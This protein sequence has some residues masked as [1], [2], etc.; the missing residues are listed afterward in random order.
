MA[1]VF[2]IIQT[3][4]NREF[5]LFGA[6][7][8]TNDNHVAL[9]YAGPRTVCGI[10]LDGDD[11]IASGDTFEGEITCISCYRIIV[12]IKSIRNWQRRT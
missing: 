11:G 7:L 6:S 9:S 1:K 3:E 2:K 10:Q 4:N 8:V 5:E 12:E